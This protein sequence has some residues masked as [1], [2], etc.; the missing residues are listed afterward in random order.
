MLFQNY[1]LSKDRRVTLTR[2][3]RDQILDVSL[4]VMTMHGE[5]VK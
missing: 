5:T 3:L 4:T 1:S 2:L